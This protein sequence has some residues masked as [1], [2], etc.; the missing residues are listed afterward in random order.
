MH[1]SSGQSGVEL[2]SVRLVPVRSTGINDL[3]Y[4]HG[5]PLNY[6]V[7]SRYSWKNQ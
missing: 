1:T 2:T 5:I 3:N 6:R 4:L 7:H